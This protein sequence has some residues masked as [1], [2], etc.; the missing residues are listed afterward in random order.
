M[1]K[2]RYYIKNIGVVTSVTWF[3]AAIMLGIFTA[4]TYGGVTNSTIFEILLIVG[5]ILTITS[6]AIYNVNL[7]QSVFISRCDDSARPTASWT[8]PW[9]RR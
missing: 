8:V 3:I 6:V 7:I 4:A 5:N 9:S 1:N 2:C